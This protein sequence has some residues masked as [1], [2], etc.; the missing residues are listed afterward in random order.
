[1][2]PDPPVMIFGSVGGLL[3]VLVFAVQPGHG[4]AAVAEQDV[5]GFLGRH[6]GECHGDDAAA[7]EGASRSTSPGLRC[8]ASPAESFLYRTVDLPEARPVAADAAR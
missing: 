5:R 2:R 4:M 1:M 3:L 7:V 6:C 8:R